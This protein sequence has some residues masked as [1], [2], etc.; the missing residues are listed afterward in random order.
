MLVLVAYVLKSPLNI[1]ADKPR[2]TRG[3][4]FGLS[5]PLLYAL[6][7]KGRPWRDRAYVQVHLSL[8]WP[9]GYKTFFILNS[10]E[11]EIYPAHKC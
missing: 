6:Y 10:A 8:R 11:Q 1:H 2:G 4:I 5:L 9:R 7:M 3:L